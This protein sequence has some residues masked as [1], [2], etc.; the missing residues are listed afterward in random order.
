MVHSV[1]EQQQV[2]KGAGR[3]FPPKPKLCILVSRKLRYQRTFGHLLDAREA[4]DGRMNVHR[5]RH[6]FPYLL[7]LP[8]G[9]PM[10][11][12]LVV[13]GLIGGLVALAGCQSYGQRSRSDAEVCQSRGYQQ[14]SS[15]YRACMKGRAPTPI[16]KI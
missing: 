13:A 7:S 4:L 11:R 8:A 10:F 12:I 15:D 5:L 3:A 14:G 6:L 9:R 1:A 16:R 2:F